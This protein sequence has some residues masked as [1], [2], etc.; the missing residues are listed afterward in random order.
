VPVQVTGLSGVKAVASGTEHALAVLS[1]GTVMSWGANVF[2][3]LGTGVKH[4]D[5]SNVPVKVDLIHTAVGVAAGDS[6]SAALLANGT[7]M[8]WG[9][10]VFGQLGIGTRNFEASDDPIAVAG[11]HTATAL[12]AGAFFS[13]ALRK[14]G[15][16]VGWGSDS[17]GELGDGM[18]SPEVVAPVEAKVT[19]VTS[20]SCGGGFGMAIVG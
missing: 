8:S 19:G 12:C 18:V 9:S 6:H 1:N 4:P 14:N 3:D 2:G 20:L 5:G 16:V 7:V 13:Q 10:N 17:Q 11:L 15:T